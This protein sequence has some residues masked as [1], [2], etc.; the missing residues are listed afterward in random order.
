LSYL[1]E[2]ITGEFDSVTSLPPTKSH[3]SQ[4]A[5]QPNTC[6]DERKVIKQ[7]LFKSITNFVVLVTELILY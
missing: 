1:T 3:P 7:S 4:L 2:F 5:T 6:N